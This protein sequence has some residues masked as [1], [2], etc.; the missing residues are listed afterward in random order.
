MNMVDWWCIENTP[1][2][3]PNDFPDEE[4]LD[5]PIEYKIHCYKINGDLD[6]KEYFD[7]LDTAI[8]RRK[9]WGESIGLKPEPSFDFAYY[10]TIFQW[11]DKINEYVRI[12][13]Y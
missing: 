7:C 5:H 1:Y 9:E 13:G 12:E 11:N 4:Y 3:E 2:P 6:H 10:P 8:R